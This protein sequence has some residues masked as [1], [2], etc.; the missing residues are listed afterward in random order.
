MRNIFYRYKDQ[1]YSIEIF[2]FPVPY[3][4]K[5]KTGWEVYRIYLNSRESMNNI[6]NIIRDRFRGH[7]IVEQIVVIDRKNDLLVISMG[8][9][10][11]KNMKSLSSE[12]EKIMTGII[13][14]RI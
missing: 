1:P 2:L 8:G 12:I 7:Y 6:Y 9:L 5:K 14:K 11:I 10:S 4:N 13:I 3:P